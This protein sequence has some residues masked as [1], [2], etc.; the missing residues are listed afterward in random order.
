MGAPLTR[1]SSAA[2][3]VLLVA[4][5]GP[6]ATAGMK[7]STGATDPRLPAPEVVDGWREEPTAL[8]DWQPHYLGATAKLVRTYRKGDRRVALY[9]YYYQG[10]RQGAELINSQ[11]VLVV[12]KDPRWQNRGDV[13][14]ESDVADGPPGRVRETVLRSAAQ[15]LMVWDWYL[16]DG[17]TTV[18]GI[19]A[20]LLEAK[21]A[22]LRS[23]AGSAAVMLVAETAATEDEARDDLRAFVEAMSDSIQAVLRR[24]DA[25][26]DL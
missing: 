10:Q 12:Q 25:G 5:I 15:R 20:K 6:I 22:L 23:G 16:I 8:T 4:A 18:N 21:A 13:E 11:N 7:Q 17:T 24:R 2:F 19:L 26:V 3:L 9:L 1:I 14:R